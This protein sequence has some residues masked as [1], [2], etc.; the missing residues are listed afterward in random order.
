MKTKSLLALPGKHVQLKDFDPADT[1]EFES[2][3]HAKA[4]LQHNIERLQKYQDLLYADRSYAL[5]LVFQGMDAAGKDSCIKHVMSGVNPEGCQVS[6]FSVPSQLEL[7]HDF[8]WRVYRELPARG[9]IGIFNRSHYEEVLVVRVHPEKLADEHI[10]GIKSPDKKFWR[11]RFD[12][13]N[14]FEQH[15]THT[16]TVIR[17]FF[18]HVSRQEQRKRFLERL[19]DPTKNWKF[20]DADLHERLS[21]NDYQ[22]CYEEAIEGTS[23]KNAPWYIIPADHKWFTHLAV[24]EII[25]QT[26]KELK[27]KYPAISQEQRKQLETAREALLHGQ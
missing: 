26:L 10:P 6:T 8:L 3:E 9:R 12:S 25:V 18:L 24:S 16:G 11:H 4:R 20:S 1:A 7:E 2:H 23:T 19:D 15:L 14:H 5:L 21:W 27:L 17:K 13:I 22:R